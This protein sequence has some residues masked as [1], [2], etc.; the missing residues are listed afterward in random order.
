MKLDWNFQR[1]GG[2]GGDLRKNP[3]H[4]GG[5]DNFWN[6]TLYIQYT[7]NQRRE[8]MQRRMPIWASTVYEIMISASSTEELPSLSILDEGLFTGY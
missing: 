4:G 3:F 2:G 1:G 6:H 7:P 5:M 8:S